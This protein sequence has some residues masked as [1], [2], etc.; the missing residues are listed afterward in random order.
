M[1]SGT[2]LYLDFSRWVAVFALPFPAFETRENGEKINNRDIVL[3]SHTAD[4]KL[5][6]HGDRSCRRTDRRWQCGEMEQE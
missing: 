3:P 4:V 2:V 6:S 1:K 5:V